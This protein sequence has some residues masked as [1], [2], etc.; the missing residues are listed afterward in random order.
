[1]DPTVDSSQPDGS[2]TTSDESLQQ[3]VRSVKDSLLGPKA[4]IRIGAWNVRT[5]YETSK[6]AQVISEMKRY[7]LDILGVSECRWTGSGRQVT[8][9]R[10]VIIYSGHEDQHVRGAA[11]IVSKEKANTLLEW[12]PVSDRMFRARFNSKNCKLTIIQCYAL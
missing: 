6:S 12:E 8:S 10:S 4:K 11:L 2:M 3:E 1:M 9:D 7:R 5:M